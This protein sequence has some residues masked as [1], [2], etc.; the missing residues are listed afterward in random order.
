[1]EISSASQALKSYE[2]VGLG[3]DALVREYT[4]LKDEIENKKWAIKELKTEV[5]G[6]DAAS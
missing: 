5:L 1:M 6:L 3:F 2:S 4:Y